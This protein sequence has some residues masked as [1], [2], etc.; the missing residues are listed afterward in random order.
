MLITVPTH[1]ISCPGCQPV[2]YSGLIT[3]NHIVGLY[4]SPNSLRQ[5]RVE[6]DVDAVVDTSLWRHMHGIVRDPMLANTGHNDKFG[7]LIFSQ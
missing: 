4:C 7:K 5:S 2:I 6:F 1:S 3:V